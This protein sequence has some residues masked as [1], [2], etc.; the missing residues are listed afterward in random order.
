VLA[1]SGD[2]AAALRELTASEQADASGSRGVT[3]TPGCSRRLPTRRCATPS[4]HARCSRSAQLRARPRSGLHQRAEAA[5]LAALGR[6]PDACVRRPRLRRARHVGSGETLK[7]ERLL[8]ES[9]RPLE[10]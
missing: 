10:R 8:Y 1:E 2:L 9:G 7:A 4:E 5:V 3:C 6:Y